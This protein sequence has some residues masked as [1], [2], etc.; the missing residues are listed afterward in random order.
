MAGTRRER[1]S[2][3]EVEVP[4]DALWGASTQRAQ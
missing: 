4:E 1:D 2:M 3:G